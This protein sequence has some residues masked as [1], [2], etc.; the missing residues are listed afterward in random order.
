M[1]NLRFVKHPAFLMAAAIGATIPFAVGAG[2][3]DQFASLPSTLTLTGV[4]RDFREV[5]TNGGHADFERNPSAGFGHYF[6]ECADT[7]D[8]DGKPVFSSTGYLKS[9]DWRDG[10]NRPIMP[11]RSYI[12]AAPGDKA[13][14]MSASQGGALTTAQAFGQ[15]FR[16]T[17]GVNM[18]R[19]LG[20]TL[21]RNPGTNTYTFNDTTD[22]AFRSLGGFFPINGD[23]LGNSAGGSQN[24]HFTFELATTFQYNKNTGQVFSFTGDDD[25]WVFIDNKLVV[26]IGGI[27][28][29]VSQ[30]VNLDRLNWLKDGQNYSLKF[31]F[32]ERH[33][34]QSNCRID[35]NLVLRT[36]TMPQVSSVF[37]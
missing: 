37:D 28:S 34:T 36:V 14:A 19:P 4:V 7:L 32:A 22:A 15:W 35:T 6:N 23:L 18:S 10:S 20:I 21:V 24:F 17:P 30:S 9:S 26:D 5:G 33:R 16:D 27:H 29:A 31:F 12:D 13:G 3:S 1:I 11:P 25:V 8:S 2:G